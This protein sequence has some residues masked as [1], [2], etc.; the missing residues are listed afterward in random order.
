[1]NTSWY[2]DASTSSL[3]T[4]KWEHIPVVIF[5]QPK[6]AAAR[7]AQEIAQPG[8]HL[9]R[10]QSCYQRFGNT[11]CECLHKSLARRRTLLEGFM[12]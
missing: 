11:K 3:E 4:S 12:R 9:R 6:L 8:A 10:A 2:Q 7:V 1:M 5:E